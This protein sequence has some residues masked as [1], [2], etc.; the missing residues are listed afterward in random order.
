MNKKTLKKM[1][2]NKKKMMNYHFQKLTIK[3]KMEI[4]IQK[5]YFKVKKKRIA[6]D[7]LVMNL[8]LK[9]MDLKDI[10]MIMKLGLVI[11]LKEPMLI[12]IS[13]GSTILLLMV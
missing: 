6:M 12:L 2:I 3:L 11:I 13:D 5:V 8:T 1:K 7:Y 4:M 10:I 9:E